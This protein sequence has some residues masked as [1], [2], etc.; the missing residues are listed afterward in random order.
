MFIWKISVKLIISQ[1]ILNFWIFPEVFYTCI[2]GLESQGLAHQMDWI[3]KSSLFETILHK[4]QSIQG[5]HRV[6]VAV[7]TNYKQK[8]VQKSMTIPEL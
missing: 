5:H 7:D 3:Q 4:L 2:R 6:E 1:K 8:Y